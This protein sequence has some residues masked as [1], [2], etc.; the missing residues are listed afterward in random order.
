MTKAIPKSTSFDIT[1][2]MGITNL[3]KYTLVKIP[4]LLI[5]DC[6]D[7][8]IEEEKYIQGTKAT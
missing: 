5:N 6:V 4:T 8:V 7:F 2:A 1:G 3:G